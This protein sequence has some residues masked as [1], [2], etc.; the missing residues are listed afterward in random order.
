[1]NRVFMETFWA[2][3]GSSGKTDIPGRMAMPQPDPEPAGN[4]GGW[5]TQREISYSNDKQLFIRL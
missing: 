2:P 5:T 3:C 1:M 4:A